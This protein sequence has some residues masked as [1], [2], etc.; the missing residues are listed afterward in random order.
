MS[1]SNEADTP[2]PVTVA[3]LLTAVPDLP[4]LHIPGIL[5]DAA[6]FSQHNFLCCRGR[7][8]FKG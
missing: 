2:V 3:D 7:G 4:V 8:C 5:V 1:A 6:Y